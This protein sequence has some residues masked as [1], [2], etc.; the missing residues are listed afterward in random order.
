MA[1]AARRPG[2]LL[3]D[4]WGTGRILSQPR[5]SVSPSAH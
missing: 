1:Q 4:P 5:T 3:P 2:Q